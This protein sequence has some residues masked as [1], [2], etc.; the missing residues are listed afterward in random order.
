MIQKIPANL[1]HFKDFGWLKTYWLFS[2]DQY[3]DPNNMHF[4]NLRVFNDDLFEAKSGF[5]THSHREMEIVTI[6]HSGAVSHNDSLGSMT[7]IQ[8]QEIQRMSAGKWI[9]HSEFNQENQPL[10]LY[11]IWFLPHTKGIDPSYEQKKFP[12]ELRQNCL[13]P[14]VV[15]NQIKITEEMPIIPIQMYS[16]AAIFLAEWEA[17]FTR[18]Y[19]VAKVINGNNS[20]RGVFLYLK[21]GHLQVDGTKLEK[22]DQLRITQQTEIEIQSISATSFILIDVEL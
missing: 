14:V 5:P 22:N 21:E 17:N 20:Q 7:K 16:N 6:V 15:G 12:I 10:H 3:V 19:S 2:F 9:A 18:T 8:E 11:Q 1:R 4:G 13:L